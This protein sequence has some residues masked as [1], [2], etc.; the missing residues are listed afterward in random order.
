MERHLVKATV[1]SQYLEEK[2]TSGASKHS[3]CHH[4]ARSIFF[5]INTSSVTIANS[6]GG[7]FI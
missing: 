5:T 1:Q 7:E 4:S 6:F 2:S 3:S